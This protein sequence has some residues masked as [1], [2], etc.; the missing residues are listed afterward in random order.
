MPPVGSV[1]SYVFY[2][3]AVITVLVYYKFKEVNGPALLSPIV[4]LKRFFDRGAQKSLD[5]SRPTEGADANDTKLK[6][7]LARAQRRRTRKQR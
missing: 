3:L 7:P 2:W 1:L 5:G 4:W 6:R